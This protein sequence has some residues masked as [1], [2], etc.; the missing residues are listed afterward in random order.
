MNLGLFQKEKIEKEDEL[1]EF[2][3]PEFKTKRIKTAEEEELD[4]K[5]KRIYLKLK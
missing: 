4:E 1:K 3:E 2:I 5:I